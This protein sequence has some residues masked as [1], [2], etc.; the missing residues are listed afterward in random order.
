[1]ARAG[2]CFLF[3]LCLPLWVAVASGLET[4]FVLAISIAVWALAEQVASVPS[5]RSI[6]LLSVAMVASLLA[7][8]DGFII[9]GVALFYLLLKRQRRAFAICAAVAAATVGLHEIVR[10]LYYGW[11]L[12]T[13]YYVK[14]AGPMGLRISNATTS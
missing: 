2:G 8:A 4:P 5:S 12:P 3:A 1:M 10:E 9:V 6:G 14:V 11:P 7:R 13:S